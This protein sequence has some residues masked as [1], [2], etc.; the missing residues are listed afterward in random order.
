MRLRPTVLSLPVTRLSHCFSTQPLQPHVRVWDSVSLATLQV[1]G[2]G[3]FERG[4]GCLDFSKAVRW[5][6]FLGV[7]QSYGNGREISGDFACGCLADLFQ[8]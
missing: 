3:T 4:V 8:Y 7:L 1:I 5:A 6:Q 2:L